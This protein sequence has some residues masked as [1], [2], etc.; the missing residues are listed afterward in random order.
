MQTVAMAV[1]VFAAAALGAQAPGPATP[2]GIIAG[3]V[4]DA[5]SGRGVGESVMTLSMVLAPG[6]APVSPAARDAASRKVITDS[7]GRFVFTGLARGR[8]TLTTSKPGYTPG[9]YGKLVPRGPG[10]QLDLGDSDR[11]PDLRILIWKHAVIAGRVFDE[12]GEPIVAAEVKVFRRSAAAGRPSVS[13]AVTAITDDRGMYRVAALEPGSYVVGV[14]STSTTL[15]TPMID[16][17]QKSTGAAR[18]EMQQALFSAAPTLSG[19]GGPSHLRVGEHLLQVQGRMVPPPAPGATGPLEIYPTV[20]YPSAKQASGGE[21]I[22]LT[23][24]AIRT[25]I[26]IQLRPAQAR[27]IRGS[28]SGPDGAVGIAAVHLLHAEPGLAG[29]AAST[30]IATT[31]ANASGAFLFLAVPPGQYVL[32]VLRLPPSQ[33]GA[34][35]T[36]VVQTP[37]GAASRGLVVEPAAVSPLPTFW[38]TQPVNVGDRDIEDLRVTLQAGFRLSGTIVFEGGTPSMPAQRFYP[39]LEPADP[40]LSAALP[41]IT[42][43]ADGSFTSAQAPAGRYRLTVPTP[44][45]WLVK[46]V[47]RGTQDL[48]ELPFELAEDMPGLT[49]TL[50]NRGA[51]LYGTVR[52]AAGSADPGATTIVFPVDPRQWVDFSSYARGMKEARTG[53][54]GTYAIA[55][56]PAGEYLVVAVPQ[57]QM[58]W[59]RHGFLES[60]SRIATRITVAE[61]EAR[62][63]DL[64]TAQVK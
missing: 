57:R 51:R 16:E 64:R 15:P 59:T 62:A 55:D 8:Y 47:M 9:N 6:T 1:A 46:S 36:T 49:V 54:D 21:S 10:A 31:V 43:A 41:E 27:Q 18:A 34:V 7:Q 52:N 50:T 30:P 63:L 4:V 22:T 53:R 48:S 26:D 60:L 13:E 33:P 40:W 38:A 61:G 56:L 3:Q 14:V 32:R 37:A 11:I 58:D 25:G 45:G 29:A 12:A 39:F 17:F 20:F 23:S 5:D 44:T 24:G 2:T 35:Q 28:L 19:P 42:V